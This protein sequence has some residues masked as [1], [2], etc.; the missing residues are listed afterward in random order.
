MQTVTPSFDTGWWRTH[1]GEE[2]FNRP[3]PSE[4]Q[5]PWGMIWID[6]H[7]EEVQVYDNPV[8]LWPTQLRPGWSATIYT[9][10]ETPQAP[11]EA[12]PWQLSM[13]AQGWESL[14]VPA[15]HFSAFRY[16]NLVNFRFTNVSE[17]VSAQREENIWFAP[18]IG[19]WV[20][21]ESWGTFYQDVGERFR[22]S[23]SRWQLLRW[24]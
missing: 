10:Y 8:P 17:R 15:G 22:E 11:D 18:E 20:A 12:L 19:R 3:P 23:S 9:P 1:L 21:R 14:V 24:T 13:H 7:W 6:P 16:H 4:V 5:A 2:S